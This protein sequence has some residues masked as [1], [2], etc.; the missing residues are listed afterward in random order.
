MSHADRPARARRLAVLLLAAVVCAFPALLFASADPPPQRALLDL[1]VNQVAKGQ[2][3]VLLRGTDVLVPV[4]AL[5]RAGLHDFG[6]RRETSG[7]QVFVSLASLGPELVYRFDEA[8]LTLSVTAPAR[9][10]AAVRIDIRSAQRPDYAYARTTSAFVNYGVNWAQESGYSATT[11]AGLSVGGVLATST[12]SRD[13]GGRITRGLSSAVFDDRAHL[14]RFVAGDSVVGDRLLGGTSFIGGLRLAREYSLDPYFVQFPTLGLSGAALTPS[15]V[16]VY[17]DNRLVRRERVQPGRFELDNVPVPTGSSQTRLVIRDAF[18]QEQEIASPFYL[19]SSVLSAGLHEYEYALGFLRSDPGAL[20]ADYGSLAAL[21]R[22]RYGF[23]NEFT[24]GFRAEAQA[25]LVSGGPSINLRL[26]FG[27][28]EAGLAASRWNNRHGG[29]AALGFAYAGRL[30]GFSLSARAYS[31]AYRSLSLLSST[32]RIRTEAAA[33]TGVR[34]WPGG[35]LNLQQAFSESQ[36]GRRSSRSSLQLSAQVIRRTYAFASLS[37]SRLAGERSKSFSA[38]VTVALGDRA[39]ASLSASASGAHPST[40]V[41]IQRSLPVGS[42]FGYRVGG[43]TGE[44]DLAGGRVQ[45]QSGFGRFEAG[46]ETIDG[47]SSASASASG[48]L[49]FI[50]G[51]VHATRAVQDGYALIRVPGV[52]GVRGFLSNHEVGRTDARGNL[53]VPN[54][55]PYYANRIGISDQDVPLDHAVSNTERVVATPY[56]G[57]AVVEFT[58]EKVQA[59]SGRVVMAVDG[60]DVVPEYGEISVASAGRLFES[61]IG[62]D[63]DFYLEGLPA[64]AHEAIVRYLGTSCRAQLVVPASNSTVASIGL[65]RCDGKAR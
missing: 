36:D 3:Y 16:E 37:V 52:A 43:G 30:A 56:R 61:P 51:S 18:G 11:E 26:P 31:N 12:F 5:E 49:V 22:H 65:V 27:E 24:G 8:A 25:G 23:T 48:G 32:Q 33:N 46:D 9:M 54:L 44:A 4:D 13:E 7:D 45:Y 15:T 47:V 55:L 19:S 40:H 41:E 2:V 53:F 57:G 59:I 58:A 60:R 34:L 38:G 10:L 1:I 14:R 63:G 17:V 21:A 35:S 62:L 39:N 50:G 64:G 28:V 20:E 42:G 6:G 29:A